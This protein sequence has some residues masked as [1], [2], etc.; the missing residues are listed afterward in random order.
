MVTQLTDEF[1][2]QLK[3]CHCPQVRITE[4]NG[5]E[6]IQIETVKKKKT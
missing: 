2:L 5:S 4:D 1:V 6:N 3:S